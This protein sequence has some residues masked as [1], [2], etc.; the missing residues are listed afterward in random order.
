MPVTKGLEIDK[1]SVEFMK[2][3]Q[4]QVMDNATLLQLV[5]ESLFG[6]QVYF[7][8]LPS[9]IRHDLKNKLMRGAKEHGAPTYDKHQLL[10]E[11]NAECIDLLGWTLVRK[12]NEKKAKDNG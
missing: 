1:E 10:A 11:F 9:D 5:Q 3:V 6:A 12:W 4:E 8:K 2:W 7:S